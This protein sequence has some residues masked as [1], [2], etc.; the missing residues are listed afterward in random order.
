MSANGDLNFPC[1][2]KCEGCKSS[3]F[4]LGS[5]GGAGAKQ[6]LEYI[7]WSW[8]GWQNWRHWSEVDAWTQLRI[9]FTH[10]AVLSHKKL[11]LQLRYKHCPRVGAIPPQKSPMFTVIVQTLYMPMCRLMEHFGFDVVQW[12]LMCSVHL[13]A[14]TGALYVVISQY[15]STASHLFRCDSIS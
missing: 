15:G 4:H 2:E 11:T 3:W 9:G 6:P 14:P 1:V 5:R 13:L 7:T 8:R 10:P 12:L